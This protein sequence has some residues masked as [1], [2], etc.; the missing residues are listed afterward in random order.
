MYNN[1]IYGMG[2]DCIRVYKDKKVLY[3]RLI[4][5]FYKEYWR[6]CIRVVVVVLFLYIYR[7]SGVN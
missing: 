4:L 5:N 6:Y 1:F 7:G 2:L 3:E